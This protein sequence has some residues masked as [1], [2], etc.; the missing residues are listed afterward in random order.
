M[1]NPRYSAGMQKLLLLPALLTVFSIVILP[2]RLYSEDP[3]AVFREYIV[4]IE[5][6]ARIHLLVQT[7]QFKEALLS[8]EYKKNGAEFIFISSEKALRVLFKSEKLARLHSR[9]NDD[10][11]FRVFISRARIFGVDT[12]GN[13]MEGRVLLGGVCHDKNCADEDFV[14]IH[15]D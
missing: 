5:E 10:A 1:G 3:G 12:A 11:I 15:A 4:D 2:I 6:T 14:V 7:V 13:A 9:L 8:G